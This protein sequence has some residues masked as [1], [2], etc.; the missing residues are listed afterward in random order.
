MG[1]RI[2]TMW[3]ETVNTVLDGFY[4]RSNERL[5]GKKKERKQMIK[6]FSMD[7]VKEAVTR[8]KTGNSPGMDDITPGVHL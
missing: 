2:T 6:Q 4:L 3:G 8:Q 7:E 5:S 1:D